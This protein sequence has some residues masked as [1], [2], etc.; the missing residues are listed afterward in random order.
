MK[1][2]GLVESG[3]DLIRR[4]DGN[5]YLQSIK[6]GTA[7][8]YAPELTESQVVRCI[9]HIDI[10]T[11]SRPELQLLLHGQPGD[12]LS[13]TILSNGADADVKIKLIKPTANVKA[14]L[15]PG[16]IGYVRLPNFEGEKPLTTCFTNK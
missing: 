8:Y 10:S 3:L 13:V 2:A 1:H 14:E 7:A 5:F 11:L 9:N 16:N 6:F 15:L 12:E 4:D